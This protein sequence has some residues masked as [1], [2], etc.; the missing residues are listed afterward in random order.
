MDNLV[1][2]PALP[3]PYSPG[4]FIFKAALVT[5]E[6]RG[7]SEGAQDPALQ[8]TTAPRLCLSWRRL[9]TKAATLQGKRALT[10]PS[11]LLLQARSPSE[12]HQ[13]GT[14]ARKPLL[15]EVMGPSSPLQADDGGILPGFVQNFIPFFII[16]TD[17]VSKQNLTKGNLRACLKED[18]NSLL[19]HTLPGKPVAG[20][21]EPE[22]RGRAQS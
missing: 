5:E 11:K 21:C 19:R 8:P 13:R 10:R 2:V 20:Q 4:H 7:C 6:R 17:Y 18:D 16:P 22:G 1:P 14:K 9:D 3:P 15:P 12:S